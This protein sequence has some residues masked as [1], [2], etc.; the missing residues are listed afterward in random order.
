MTRT[1]DVSAASGLCTVRTH[2]FDDQRTNRTEKASRSGR[3]AGECPADAEPAL[4][5]TH[6]YDSADRLID[7]GCTYDAYGRITTTPGGVTNA[8]YVNDLVRSQQTADARMTWTLDPALRQRSFVSEKLVNDQRANAV[9]KVNHYGDDSDEPRWIAEDITQNNNITRNVSSPE[10][11][12]AVTTGLAGNITLQLTNLHGDVVATVGVTGGQIDT[13]TV[14]DSDEFGLPSTDT[15]AAATARYGWL[16]GKQRSAEAL[17]GVLLMGA[18]LYH[19]GT[20]RFWQPDPEPGGGATLYDYCAGDPVNCSDLD[21]RW[22]WLKS[23]GNVVASVPSIWSSSG[24]KVLTSRS[25]LRLTIPSGSTAEAG[26]M[27]RT[28]ASA[29]VSSCPAGELP[30]SGRS[31]ILGRSPVSW[32]TTSPSAGSTPTLW[33]LAVPLSSSIMRI[34]CMVVNRGLSLHRRERRRLSR[35]IRRSTA[36]VLDVRNVKSR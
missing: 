25:P 31:V 21:G 7:E 16:G 1:Q 20:G 27:P 22:R 30:R 9:T 6:S 18:R 19:P 36:V 24:L 29:T 17:G 35:K 34:V 32:S 28:S 26:P 11:D 10:G 4:A 12:L 5:E 3:T 13:V 33:S 8:F 14:L 15:P 23:L 2:A